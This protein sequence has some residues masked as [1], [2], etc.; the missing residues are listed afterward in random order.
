MKKKKVIAG[1][2]IA[3]IPSIGTIVTYWFLWDKFPQEW[4]RTIIVTV[5]L[6]VVIINIVQLFFIEPVDIFEDKS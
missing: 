2:N 3:G 6:F 1:K 4:A 5:F